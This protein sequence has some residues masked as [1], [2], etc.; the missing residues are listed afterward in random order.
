MQD[1]LE[2]NSN[3]LEND[4]DQMR[5]K[6]EMEKSAYQSQDTDLRTKKS[7]N[8]KRLWLKVG[9]KIKRGT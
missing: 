7:A 4:E 3:K 5:P 8:L 9:G 2:N 6:S 1:E